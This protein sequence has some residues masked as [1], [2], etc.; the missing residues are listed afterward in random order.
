MKSHVLSSVSSKIEAQEITHSYY[1]F[2]TQISYM[3]KIHANKLVQRKGLQCTGTTKIIEGS[4]TD[5]SMYSVLKGT[6]LTE[7]VEDSDADG[8]MYGLA[9]GTVVTNT[10]ED[11]DVDGFTYT[12]QKGTKQTCVIEESDLDMFM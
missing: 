6:V 5:G 9:K 4:D 10:V 7:T 2:N 1:D 11:S 12:L 3:D 8:F